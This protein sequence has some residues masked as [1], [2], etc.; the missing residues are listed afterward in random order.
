MSIKIEISEE[1]VY[2]YV[3]SLNFV[4]K[5]LEGNWLGFGASY[6]LQLLRQQIIAEAEAANISSVG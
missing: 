6:Q 5:E 3:A 1:Q 4:I 2:A